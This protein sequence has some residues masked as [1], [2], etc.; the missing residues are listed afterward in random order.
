[1]KSKNVICILAKCPRPGMIKPKLDEFLGKKE[2]SFLARAF[3]LDTISTVLRV[4]RAESVLAFCPADSISEFQDILF[5][6]KSEEQDK[7]ISRLAEQIKL[8]PQTGANLGERL[9][10][11]SRLLF[12]SNETRRLLF[13]CSDNPVLDPVLLKAALE[14]LKTSNAVLGPTFDGGFYLL[15]VSG[16]LPHL[17]EGIDWSTNFTYRQIVERLSA[18]N[19]KWQELEISYDVDGPDELEQLYCDIDTLRLTGKNGIALHTE[20]CLANMKRQD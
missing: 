9:T 6:F 4:P 20:R 14:L 19:L 10:N 17:F 12:E 1:V 11:L 7:K 8:L 18:D 15:G 13:I 3:L 2:V 16:H 5:L